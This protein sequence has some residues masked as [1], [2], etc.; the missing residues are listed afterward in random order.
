M[1]H[2]TIKLLSSLFSV[3]ISLTIIGE[4]GYLVIDVDL[5]DGGF[6][7]YWDME[8][9]ADFLSIT[10]RQNPDVYGHFARIS[11]FSANQVFLGVWVC[12]VDPE[13]IWVFMLTREVLNGFGVYDIFGL[14]RE[15]NWHVNDNGYLVLLMN[16]QP[17]TPEIFAFEIINNILTVTNQD[18][19]G[20]QA[21]YRRTW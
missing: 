7:Q 19:D 1:A 13:L 9:C 8:V 16:D 10:H 4:G 21:S 20:L 3:R 17:E 5:P 6:T 15:F 14:S 18:E 11:S 2:F 12:E